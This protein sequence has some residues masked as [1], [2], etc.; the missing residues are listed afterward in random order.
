MPTLGDRLYEHRL[1]GRFCDVELLPSDSSDGIKCHKLVLMASSEYFSCMFSS[2]MRETTADCVRLGDCRSDVLLALIDFL[3]KSERPLGITCDN[4]LELFSWAIRCD[5]PKLSEFCWEFIR[6]SLGPDNAFSV[7]SFAIAHHLKDVRKECISMIQNAFSLLADA[8]EWSDL[9]YGT[10]KEILS[11]QVRVYHEELVL[12]ILMRWTQQHSDEK[13]ILSL[14][15]VDGISETSVEKYKDFLQ[16]VHYV[17]KGPTSKSPTFHAHL[18]LQ[19]KHEIGLL[20]VICVTNRHV[21]I[22]RYPEISISEYD[23]QENYR[24]M[25]CATHTDGIVIG[26]CRNL[27]IFSYNHTIRQVKFCENLQI[28]RGAGCSTKEAAVLDVVSVGNQLWA[29]MRDSRSNTYRLSFYSAHLNVWDSS[30]EVPNDAH[31]II[32]P[33]TNVLGPNLFILRKN[34]NLM[35]A[36]V[37][38]LQSYSVSELQTIEPGPNRKLFDCEGLYIPGGLVMIHGKDTAC[39]FW[40]SCYDETSGEWKPDVVRLVHDSSQDDEDVYAYKLFLEGSDVYLIEEWSSGTFTLHR[41][42]PQDVRWDIVKVFKQPRAR[43]VGPVHLND[44]NAESD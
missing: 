5:L 9:S 2:G 13:D 12:D 21:E 40:T 36:P 32:G 10:L 28:Q 42:A 8:D 22:Y 14:V 33:R 23:R 44:C 18:M 7:L 1:A 35:Y 20:A 4:V 39:D 24:V 25:C 11:R 15:D 27:G 26:V 17:P 34:G 31:K 38:H 37:S 30:I 29:L 6:N 43:L 19:Y 41:W 3:Y 16:S